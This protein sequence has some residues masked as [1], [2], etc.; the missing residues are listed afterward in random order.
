MPQQETGPPGA[1]A[2]VRVVDF[3]TGIAGPM[4]AGL[5]ADFGADVV[6]VELP[7]GDPARGKA[8]FALWNRNKRGCLIDPADP[9]ARELLRALLAG[10]DVCVVNAAAPPLEGLDPATVTALHPGLVYLN[11]PPYAETTPWEGGAES[12]GLLS[13]YMSV[14]L[15]QNSSSGTPVDPAFPYLLYL[16]GIWGA[17]CGVAALLERERSGHGQVVTVGGVHG[18]LVAGSGGLLIDRTVPDKV[19]AFGAG[20]PNAMY[21]RYRCADNQWIFL[22]TLTEKFQLAALRELELAGILDDE[23]IGGDLDALLLPANQ[24]WVRARFEE[25]F[26]RHTRDEWLS[27]FR[28][29]GIPAGPLFDRA[30]FLASEAVSALGL[31]LEVE[32]PTWGSVVMPANSV[33]LVATPAALR[34]PAPALGEHTFEPGQWPARPAPVAE[35]PAAPGPLHGVRVLDLGVVLAGPFAGALLAELG[36]DVIKVEIPAGDSWRA[37]G[38]PYIRG[39]RGLAIDL[40]APAGRDAFRALVRSADAVLD[41]FRAGVLGRLGADYD[42]L[43]EVRPDII[44]LSITGFGEA[45]PLAAEPAFDPLLQARSGMMSAQGGAGD[46]VLLTVPVNDVTTGVASVLG[47]VV[48]L[49]HRQRTGQGQRIWT[50]L[51]GSAATAQS[52]E[53]VEAAGREPARQGGPDFLGPGVLDRSYQAADGWV[54]VQALGGDALAGLRRCGL[55]TGDP[56]SDT[57]LA[58]L[59][60]RETARRTRAELV[61]QL[62]GSGLAAVPV[63]RLSELAAD[64]ELL[65]TGILGLL[66]RSP[67]TPIYAPLRYAFFSRTQNRD[68]PLPPAVGQHSAEVLREAGLAGPVIEELIANGTVV[69]GGRFVYRDLPTYR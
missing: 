64:P 24:A 41:N 65:R 3:C 17:A 9:S 4:A 67:L 58:A 26:L 57:E 20:G 61:E 36:A 5:L 21:T 43:R 27:L 62:A 69:Q 56:A 48:A 11:M 54:R 40:S 38:M 39:Q 32:D 42:S 8:S 34:R 31:R 7:G 55:L 12:A 18:V 66:D 50:T 19:A 63:R 53:L 16:Q 44:S 1:L 46:P 47:T 33:N 51:V 6:K 37:R 13:A 22:A 45:S 60:E 14:S 15:R 28:A 59:L 49:F 29:A 30:E 52:E 35:A 23:R 2:G 10:A 68:L 25:T